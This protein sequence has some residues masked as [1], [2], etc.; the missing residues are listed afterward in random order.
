MRGT[1]IA[2]H[3]P[4]FEN[5]LLASK[6]WLESGRTPHFHFRAPQAPERREWES[7]GDV[8]ITLVLIG[9]VLYNAT[10]LLRQEEGGYL[11]PLYEEFF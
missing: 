5:C 1:A 9:P 7:P 3:V 4:S 8:L 10:V 11:S 6:L 2:F